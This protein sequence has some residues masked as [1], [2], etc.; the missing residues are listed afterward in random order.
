MSA[1]V[2]MT[3]ELMELLLAFR[4]NMLRLQAKLK[5]YYAPPE[6]V[7]LSLNLEERLEAL[8]KHYL[9]ERLEALLKH[10]YDYLTLP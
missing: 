1:F 5:D 7:Q 3:P 8:L 9:E 6:V 2:E 4:G 10:F